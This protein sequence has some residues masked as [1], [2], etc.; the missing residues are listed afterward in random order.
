MAERCPKTGI[1][2]PYVEDYEIDDIQGCKPACFHKDFN[3]GLGRLFPEECPLDISTEPQQKRHNLA[4][5]N[6]LAGNCICKEK[7][8]CKWCLVYNASDPE[9]AV[10]IEERLGKEREG[11]E[12]LKEECKSILRP[13]VAEIETNPGVVAYFDL[14]IIKRAK[15][16]IKESPSKNTEAE[17]EV[18]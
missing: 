9:L 10:I 11:A 3:D 1:K 13:I 17:D 8:T 4:T 2:C 15:D 14:R 7:G 12:K 6:I 18:R 16:F 5:A